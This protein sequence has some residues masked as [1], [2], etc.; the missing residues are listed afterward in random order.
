MALPTVKV[1]ISNGHFQESLQNW[2]DRGTWTT[3]GSYSAPSTVL[4]DAN[5]NWVV[6]EWIGY[7]VV[8]DTNESDP[9]VAVITDNTVNTLTVTGNHS[10]LTAGT[11]TYRIA[12]GVVGTATASNS[13]TVTIGSIKNKYGTTVVPEIN[14]F[15]NMKIVPDK[16]DGTA[17]TIT[18]NN[19]TTVTIG[20]AIT[21]SSTSFEIG[22]GASASVYPEA[23]NISAELNEPKQL[24]AAVIYDVVGTNK[25]EQEKDID[26][27]LML[28]SLVR[29]TETTGNKILF[30]G[31][32]QT[33]PTSINSELRS[34]QFTAY[35]K[36]A[37]LDYTVIPATKIATDGSLPTFGFTSSTPL[38]ESGASGHGSDNKIYQTKGFEDYT[39]APQ[40]LGY[41]GAVNSNGTYATRTSG[42]STSGTTLEPSSGT[43]FLTDLIKVGAVVINTTTKE[44]THIKSVT[45]SNTIVTTDSIWTSGDEY[46]ILSKNWQVGEGIQSDADYS[47]NAGWQMNIVTRELLAAP[48][49]DEE[50][51]DAST[52][53]YVGR[54]GSVSTADVGIPFTGR[55]WALLIHNDYIEFVHYN[56]YLYDSDKGK[57]Y[58][59]AY[60]TTPQTDRNTRGDLTNAWSTTSSSYVGREWASGSYL[61]EVFPNRFGGDAPKVYSEAGNNPVE[62]IGVVAA[63]GVI[64]MS[65]GDAKWDGQTALY[66]HQFSYD[67]DASSASPDKGTTN[68]ALDIS[69]AV[70]TAVTGLTDTSASNEDIISKSK[71]TGGAGLIFDTTNSLETGIKINNLEYKAFGNSST[72]IQPKLLID[73]LCEDSG[74]LFD[75]RFDD[76]ND[77]V[78]FKPLSQ[79]ALASAD[80]TLAAGSVTSLT[81]ERDVSD[82][83]SAMLLQVQTPDQNYFSRENIIQY[84][85]N[86]STAGVPTSTAA[87][88]GFTKGSYSSGSSIPDYFWDT[89]HL[90]GMGKDVKNW[91]SSTSPNITSP[92]IHT[93]IWK[94]ASWKTTGRNP[95][96]NNRNDTGFFGIPSL[97]DDGNETPLHLVTFWFRNG[98]TLDIEKFRFGTAY[99]GDSGANGCTYRVEVS[100][101]IDI[102]DPLASDTTWQRFND[103]SLSLTASSKGRVGGRHFE[104]SNCQAKDVKGMRIVALASPFAQNGYWGEGTEKLRQTNADYGYKTYGYGSTCETFSQA[105][106]PRDYASK[107]ARWNVNRQDSWGFDIDPADATQENGGMN[108]WWKTGT[109]Y[110]TSA[111]VNAIEA[112]LCSHSGTATPTN[113][114]DR[115]AGYIQLGNFLYDLEV[116]GVGKKAL[117]VRVT[118]DQ[119]T[120]DDVERKAFS[121]SY[122]KLASMGYKTN[123]I[124][125][126]NFSFSE[127][128]GLGQQFLD[129]KLR[130]FQARD[131]SLDGLSPFVNSNNLPVLGQTIAIADDTQGTPSA[132]SYSGIMTQYEF[133]MDANGTRFDFR[134][135][136]YDTFNT[137][138]YIQAS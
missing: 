61:I 114:S 102:T 3:V 1:A 14:E 26:N 45:D 79:K 12:G 28:G 111:F 112:S 71:M 92:I 20:T 57:Y 121:P 83:Y 93:S 109:P 7:Y 49:D 44:V 123:P 63:E 59:N 129:D 120:K 33:A 23:I 98:I 104:L 118:K 137:A 108:H 13:T 78:I 86:F 16:L 75:L 10:G 127:A 30:K 131:Y 22:R 124:P 119:T 15:V 55:A 97:S 32:I 77:K 82:V 24:E 29:V 43:P 58:L 62:E 37:I 34:V 117:F 136:D 85:C 107:E 19:A 2:G 126:E 76:N 110:A 132:V 11:D 100:T 88:T 38:I 47:T 87:Q 53:I 60:N 27:S 134:L 39:F 115:H 54:G 103:S 95:N 81:R 69:D 68:N 101:D 113:S 46:V 128:Q 99:A 106:S 133:T 89:T 35:D 8:V 4:T 135:E 40:P 48:A 52:R 41:A 130:R 96:Q 21:V 125:L 73:K 17:Y 94:K 66:C 80:V 5:A 42:G 56:G 31:H 9:T 50:A 122:K 51:A 91:N 72:P 25:F 84:G 65:E 6:D 90:R 138:S 36:L 70:R 18:A 67:G 74:L 116:R 64:K 105:D